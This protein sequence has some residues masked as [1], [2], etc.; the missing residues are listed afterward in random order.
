MAKNYYRFTEINVWEGETWN[1]YIPCEGNEEAF[2]ALHE[3]LSGMDHYSGI[4]ETSLEPVPASEVSALCKHSKTGY[5]REHN[6]LKGRLDA[7]RV[8]HLT[9]DNVDD[10]YKGGIEGFMVKE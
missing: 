7:D 10:L 9:V 6:K 2:A 8:K 5:M 3:A 4:Y 1:F